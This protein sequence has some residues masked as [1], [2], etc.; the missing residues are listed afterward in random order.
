M[1]KDT[2]SII[3]FP[4]VY[5]FR[6]YGQK[7][8]KQFVGVVALFEYL[9]KNFWHV[10]RPFSNKKNQFERDQIFSLGRDDYITNLHYGYDIWRVL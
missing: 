4:I 5:E 6:E 10:L 3:R 9:N 7:E 2:S 8:I 1:I